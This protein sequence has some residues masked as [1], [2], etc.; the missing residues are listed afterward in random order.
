MSRYLQAHTRYA[1]GASPAPRWEEASQTHPFLNFKKKGVWG[2][3]PSPKWVWATAHLR[4]K[5]SATQL[6]VRGPGDRV[7][8]LD[9]LFLASLQLEIPGEDTAFVLDILA[10]WPCA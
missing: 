2:E 9:L 5:P 6:L 10:A 1:S 3:A 4:S 7:I 8:E